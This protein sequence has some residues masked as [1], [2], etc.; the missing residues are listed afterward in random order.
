MLKGNAWRGV[1]APIRALCDI[2][3]QPC[4]SHIL[5]FGRTCE[6]ILLSKPDEFIHMIH[7]LMTLLELIASCDG[8]G[9]NSVVHS[10]HEVLRR[11]E[12]DRTE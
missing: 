6:V 1:T 11:Q 10:T 2:T 8:D 12:T 7:T 3:K 5:L 4:H 9:S